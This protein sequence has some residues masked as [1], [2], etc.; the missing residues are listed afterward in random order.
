[1][2]WSGSGDY[3]RVSGLVAE[4]KSLL[5]DTDVLIDVLRLQTEAITFLATLVDERSPFISVIS[6]MEII[7]GC[8]NN[9]ELDKAKRFISRFRVVSVNERIAVTAIGL[10]E[11]YRLSHGLLIPDALIA[12]TS[13]SEGLPLLTRNQKDFRFIEDLLLTNA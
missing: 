9:A 5:I 4:D 3:G 8:R 6:W 12:A 7:V 10:L 11:R 13:I 1:M 2:E